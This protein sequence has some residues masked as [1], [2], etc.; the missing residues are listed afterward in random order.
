[1][2]IHSESQLDRK[3]VEMLRMLNTYLNHFPKHEKYGLAQQIR[4]SAYSLYGFIIESQKRY[5]K[6]C[7][8]QLKA[9]RY[10][11]YVDDSLIVGITRAEALAHKARIVEFLR[12]EL[13]LSL[14]K[15][16]IAP[17]SRGINFV[18]YR[19]W[20]SR[21]F[22]RKH[23]LYTFRRSARRGLLESVVS[24]LGHACKTGSH[25]HMINHLQEHHHDL[26]RRLPKSIYRAYAH[27]AG[28][29]AAGRPAPRH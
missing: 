14:S 26:Y 17:V 12:D 2:T 15:S 3:F 29:A 18:G 11:R 28:A 10:C 23:S 16:T 4:Q 8:R 25:R 20:R 19:T 21:R 9:Q 13:G 22:V 6:F 5:H 24:S 1:M 27:H 7:K